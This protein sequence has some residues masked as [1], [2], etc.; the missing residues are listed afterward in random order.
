MPSWRYAQAHFSQIFLTQGFPQALDSM[1]DLATLLDT[2]Q[3]DRFEPYMAELEGLSATDL[4]VFVNAL[5]DQ[6]RFVASTFHTESVRLPLC[7]MLAQFALYKKLV[8]FNPKF[9]SILELGPG[10]GYLG[11]FLKNHAGLKRYHQAECIESFYMLQHLVDHWCF[12]GR[13]DERAAL[14]MPG[15]AYAFAQKPSA[16]APVI[17]IPAD[18]I[19]HH[20]PW[21]RAADHEAER[22]DIITANAVLN[23]MNE[24]AFLQYAEI[25]AK[26]LK[27]DGA[28]VI[29][30]LG[31]FGHQDTRMIFHTLHRLKFAQLV[32]V[33]NGLTS[34]KEFVVANAVY[35]REGHPNFERLYAKQPGQIAFSM[36]DPTTQ[37]MYFPQ[38]DE[39]RRVYTPAEIADEVRARVTIG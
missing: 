11:F 18:P 8:G 17:E 16:A 38:G 21:W 12:P 9:E 36:S 26:A 15:D 34:K 1:A 29:Q 2:M 39:P 33:S 25:F 27:P 24:A 22:F 4:A 28:L 37:R 13:V 32:L 20:V 3:E 10:C 5:A 23:E 6:A 35:V 14:R 19:V 31:G 7:T 30:C